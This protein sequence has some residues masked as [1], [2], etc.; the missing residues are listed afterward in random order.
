MGNLRAVRTTPRPVRH[1]GG[2]DY[3]D[4]RRTAMYRFFDEDGHLLYVGISVDPT[5]RIEQHR[6]DKPWFV[7]EVDEIEVEWFA[8]RVLALEAEEVAIW[9]ENP[10]YNVR[11]DL[12][13]RPRTHVRLGEV[14]GISA[15][16]LERL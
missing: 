3:N 11:R 5:R 14:T 4:K 12:P 2:W 8:T 16:W 10:I 9:R 7:G 1:V 13:E 6:K 15:D